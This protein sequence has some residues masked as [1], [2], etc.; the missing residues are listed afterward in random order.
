[1]REMVPAESWDSL[2]IARLFPEDEQHGDIWGSMGKPQTLQAHQQRGALECHEDPLLPPPPPQA[3]MGRWSS[4]LLHN[5]AICGTVRKW[6][7]WSINISEII[8]KNGA[9]I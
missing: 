5:S 9:G 8:L 3:V 1:M 6:Q 4:S 7:L 2:A